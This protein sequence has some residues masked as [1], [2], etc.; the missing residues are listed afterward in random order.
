MSWEIRPTLQEYVRVGLHGTLRKLASAY[1]EQERDR[2]VPR[3]DPT[4]REIQ[5]SLRGDSLNRALSPN[6]PLPTVRLYFGSPLR[7]L[8]VV[9]THHHGAVPRTL[10]NSLYIK[11][12]SHVASPSQD[13]RQAYACATVSAGTP[14]GTP[15]VWCATA[16]RHLFK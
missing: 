5:Q 9:R 4:R 1:G 16:L 15:T 7:Q 10:C 2:S 8:L 14:A 6:P 3:A 13:T 11:V 12:S